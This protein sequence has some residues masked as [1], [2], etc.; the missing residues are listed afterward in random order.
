MDE[1]GLFTDKIGVVFAGF[2]PTL[3]NNRIHIL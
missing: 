3:Y 1:I 2:F